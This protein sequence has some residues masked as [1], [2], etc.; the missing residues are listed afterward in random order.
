VHLSEHEPFQLERVAQQL[1][2]RKAN[3]PKEPKEDELLQA[4]PSSR[5]NSDAHTVAMTEAMRKAGEVNTGGP[6]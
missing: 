2:Q 6:R 5:W 1:A 3:Q 4:P